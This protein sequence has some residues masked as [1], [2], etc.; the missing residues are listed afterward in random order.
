MKQERIGGRILS[1]SL[2][3]LKNIQWSSPLKNAYSFLYKSFLLFLFS[4]LI[5]QEIYGEQKLPF[6]KNQSGINEI[7]SISNTDERAVEFLISLYETTIKKPN[8]T[9]DFAQKVEILWLDTYPLKS[10]LLL[11]GKAEVAQSHG[12][13]INATNN[14]LKAIQLIESSEETPSKKKILCMAYLAYARY[15]QVT[16]DKKGIDFGYKALQIAE[17]IKFSIGEIIA[18][19]LIGTLIGYFNKDYQLALKHYQKAEKLLPKLNQNNTFLKYWVLG[20]IAKA[21]SDL[22]Y[23]E[24]S[25]DYKLNFLTDSVANDNILLLIAVYN[26]LGTNYFDLKRF[27]KAEKALQTTIDLMK[28]HEVEYHLGVPLLRMGL[29]KLAQKKLIQAI[30]YADAIDYWLTDNKF[31]GNYQI[32]FYQFKSKIAK[33]NEDYEQALFWIEKASIEQDSIDKI[34]TINNLSKLEKSTK[35]KEITQEKILLEKKLTLNKIIITSQIIILLAISLV[36][37][38]SIFFRMSF[39]NKTKELKEAYNFILNKKRASTVPKT[40]VTLNK[41]TL[42][43]EINE[44]LKQKILHALDVNKVFL[45]P[46]LTLKKFADLL[47]S[48]TSY[49]SQTI[50]EGCGRNFSTLINEYRIKE[51]LQFFEEGQHQLFTI[52]SLYKKAGFKSKSAFQKAFKNSEGVTASHYLEHQFTKRKNDIKQ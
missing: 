17:G 6:D 15:A 44:D 3:L 10:A 22:G 14:T 19:D 32:S 27:D 18:H 42:P 28:Q 40:E 29:I 38:F 1:L 9:K 12:S 39:Y 48:N 11:L 51:I 33:A 5:C 2:C 4:L 50:N 16:K 36:T 47:S 43:K 30:S 20:N 34:V 49:V 7:K 37:I 21:W 45:S 23:I 31:I 8:K 13:F 52:E 35:L 25:I 24:K 46:D 26:N 41:P